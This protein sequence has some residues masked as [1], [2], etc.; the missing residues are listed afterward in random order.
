[1]P[2]PVTC[3]F[4]EKLGLASFGERYLGVAASVTKT[5]R[6]PVASGC[7]REASW[8]FLSLGPVGWS[9]DFS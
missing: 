2:F 8:V 9:L 1:M 7:H 4:L 3:R 6:C 5:A